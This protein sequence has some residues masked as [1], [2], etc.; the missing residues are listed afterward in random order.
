MPIAQ[1]LVAYPQSCGAP[2]ICTSPIQGC[3][4]SLE[5]GN[6]SCY[7][8]DLTASYQNNEMII[9]ATWTLPTNMTTINLVWKV[10]IIQSTTLQSSY[11]GSGYFNFKGTLNLFSGQSAS[12]GSN[13]ISKRNVSVFNLL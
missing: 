1:A 7:I 3:D 8:S 10:D 12:S 2:K 6:L 4:N 5:G 11:Y 13:S 9:F